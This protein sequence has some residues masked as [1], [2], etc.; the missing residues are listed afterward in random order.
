MKCSAIQ[1][2]VRVGGG[3]FKRKGG[4]NLTQAAARGLKAAVGSYQVFADVVCAVGK[5]ERLLAAV[6]CC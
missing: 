6:S 3:G 5:S 2:I 1:L 4:N